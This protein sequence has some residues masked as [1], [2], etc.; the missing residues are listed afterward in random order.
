[1][2][3]RFRFQPTDRASRR[4]RVRAGGAGRAAGIGQRTAVGGAW[5]GLVRCWAVSE[6]RGCR[7]G[8]VCRQRRARVKDKGAHSLARV[9]GTWGA[10]L[11]ALTAL[12]GLKRP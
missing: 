4:W 5:T 1:M 12:G 8:G 10:P 3:E 9:P 6:G 7:E 2:A 11:L